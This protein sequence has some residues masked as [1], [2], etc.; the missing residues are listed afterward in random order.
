MDPFFSIVVPVFNQEGKMDRCVESLKNQTFPGFEAIF[1][2]DASTDGSLDSLQ[3]LAKEDERFRIVRHEKNSSVLAA[4]YTGMREAAGEYLL[5]VDSDDS[6]ST[7]ACQILYERIREDP[8]DILFFGT[9]MIPSGKILPA[10][11]AEEPLRCCL[12]SSAAPSVWKNCYSRKVIA[13]ALERSE[14]FYCN[15]GEDCYMSGVFFSC[16][17]T[18]SRLEDVLYCY[19]EG[20]GISSAVANSFEKTKRDMGFAEAAGDRIAAYIREYAPQYS[21][22]AEKKAENMMR[23]VMFQHV[24]YEEDWNKVF[25]YMELFHSDKHRKIFE[26]GCRRI[27]PAKVKRSLGMKVTNEDLQ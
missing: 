17:E 19:T 14:P 27:L 15:I 13:K 20:Q 11:S 9:R 24:Y 7:D 26:Y 8:A 6:L 12:D 3:P 22:L 1:V 4:R 25:E 10:Q 5:F 18:F 23:V 16:A 2:D 21:E